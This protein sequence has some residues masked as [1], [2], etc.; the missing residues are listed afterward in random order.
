M[1]IH[2]AA[3]PTITLKS[4][5]WC[6]LARPAGLEPATLGLEARRREA[7]AAG[8]RCPNVFGPLRTA[9]RSS[10]AILPDFATLLDRP[11]FVH[12]LENTLARRAF[13]KGEFRGRKVGVLLQNGRGE[14]SRNLADPEDRASHDPCAA[15][16]CFVSRF[17]AANPGGEFCR[18][19]DGTLHFAAT[20]RA[21]V[22]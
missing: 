3:G 18:P 14:Y 21:A 6:G 16:T 10:F 9:A 7:T 4:S 22:A 11:E 12:G 15:S 19:T 17:A 20:Q 8:H 1:S 2:G 13:L 5:R